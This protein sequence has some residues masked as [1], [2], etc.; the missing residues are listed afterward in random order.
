MKKIS[1]SSN[2]RDSKKIRRPSDKLINLKGLM[3]QKNFLKTIISSL[4]QKYDY[5]IA[6]RK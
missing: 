1:T 6:Q 2:P 5:D 4:T 3:K